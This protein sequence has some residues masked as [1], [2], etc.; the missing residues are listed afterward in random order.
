VAELHTSHGVVYFG[1][2]PAPYEQ[3]F[4][5]Q[6]VLVIPEGAQEVLAGAY[7]GGVAPGKPADCDRRGYV[8]GAVHLLVVLRRLPRGLRDTLMLNP[9]SG[10]IQYATHLA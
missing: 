7:R 10:S 6:R 2:H 9:V 3:A 4:Y 5:P 8:S 1:T